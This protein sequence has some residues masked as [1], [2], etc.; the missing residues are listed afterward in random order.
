[1]AADGRRGRIARPSLRHRLA[2]ASR[3]NGARGRAP[4][5]G[6]RSSWVC[7]RQ[8]HR[9]IDARAVGHR[10]R[11]G[12]A[13]RRRRYAQRADPRPRHAGAPRA[14]D[15]DA[16]SACDRLRPRAV[17]ARA[18]AVAGR[19]PGRPA[20]SGRDAGRATRQP[21]R[22]RPR[23]L[24]RGRGRARRPGH[25]RPRGSRRHRLLGAGDRFG[26]HAERVPDRG[27]AHLRAHPRGP[28]PRGGAGRGLGHGACR[29][30]HGESRH[31]SG[32]GGART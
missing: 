20:R 8:G 23:A 14:V 29:P 1:M 6:R 31:A 24:S 32:Y 28:R 4:G 27:T 19:P 21:R 9:G 13:G 3:G 17:C 5:A 10:G 11:R 26:R 15:A 25:A 16:T 18:A 12:R 2:R 22:R 30:G 7:Q